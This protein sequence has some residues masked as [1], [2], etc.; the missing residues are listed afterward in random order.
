MKKV[1]KMYCIFIL[2][3]IIMMGVFQHMEQNVYYRAAKESAKKYTITYEQKSPG[4]FESEYQ[5]PDDAEGL[6]LAFFTY[7]F[8]SQVLI[9]DD[10]V[11]GVKLDE[12][13]WNRSTGYR[14]NFVQ[15][16]KSDSGKKV[17]IVLDTDYKDL[18]PSTTL[19]VG[20]EV[21]IYKKIVKENWFRFFLLVLVFLM[22]AMLF[23]YSII[24]LK[25]KNAD[26]SMVHFSVFSITLA[27]W[28]MI[29]S[30]IA[31]LLPNWS[32]ARMVM[33]H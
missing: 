17:K 30:P 22:G 21:G 4:V 20:N 19:Y 15:L 7:H 24:F 31:D 28:A 2:A 3:L 25:L 12:D 26:V 1:I 9:G 29:E 14:M 13:S 32:I 18:K 10:V 23:L 16:K 8:E 11:Y 6:Y 27:L 33:D 5:I